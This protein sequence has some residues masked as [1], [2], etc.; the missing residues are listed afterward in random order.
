MIKKLI[1]P[2]LILILVAAG[3][4]L[5]I[6]ATQ[7]IA[8]ALNTP[9]AP[10]LKTAT[11]PVAVPVN[12]ATVPALPVMAAPQIIALQML[13]VE[14]GWA[15]SETG[16]LRT[17]DG[18]V[19]WYN[20]TPPGVSAVGF[21]A[22]Y[23]FVD[24]LHAWVVISDMGAG[25]GTLYH[26]MDGG[27]TWSTT[28]TPFAGTSLRFVDENTGWVLVGL[29][30]AM[31]HESVAIFRTMDGGASWS[32]VFINDPGATGATDSLPLVGDK[33]G[34]AAISANTA[35]VTGATPASDEI[36][37]YIS[38]DGGVTWTKQALGMPSDYAGGMTNTYLPTFFGN[39][40]GVLPVG[41]Y[42]NT[43]GTVFFNS[44]D[45]GLTWTASTPV[46][47]SGKNS[48]ATPNDL[49]VWDG[50][51][52]L[53]ASHDAGV[54]WA[55]VAPN[56]NIADT[57]MGFQFVDA[58]NGWAVTG[59]ASSHYSLYKTTDGGATWTPLIP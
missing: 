56:I 58:S 20:A 19:T 9:V 51:P 12:T 25:T 40:T 7:P 1:F 29:D 26:T 37:I 43:S 52:A 22:G 31:S 8:P 11:A 6:S 18:G 36:Y 16:V 15:I 55:T 14:D 42:S 39:S 46:A 32:Q 4:N 53:Y 23:Q 44:A 5:P 2:A 21:A 45:G 41:L 50:G 34:I 35:W 47:L 13:G 17:A 30:A 3:C 49:F 54:T 48:V 28:T 10:V 57:L 24:A 38:Q 59:D 27:S 33:N